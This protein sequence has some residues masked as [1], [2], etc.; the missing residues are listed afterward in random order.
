MDYITVHFTDKHYQ[1]SRARVEELFG[2][3]WE[4]DLRAMER[5]VT[6]DDED[7]S[8]GFCSFSVGQVANL[9]RLK[10]LFREGAEYGGK[11]VMT[12]HLIRK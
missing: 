7:T 2:S 1:V 4:Q 5:W 10:S 11:C 6:G 8:A 3:N 9:S 12:L